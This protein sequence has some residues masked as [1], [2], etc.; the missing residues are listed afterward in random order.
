MLKIKGRNNR[1]IFREVQKPRSILLWIFIL[2][3]TFYMWYI[4]IQQIIL[5]NPVGNKPAPDV[6]L[7]IIWLFF[8]VIVPIITLF[9]LRLIVEVRDDGLYIRYMPF[10]FSYKQFLDK[11]IKYFETINYSPIKRFGGW[12]IR[13]NFNGQR[14]YNMDGNKA[15]ELHFKNQIIVIGTRKP[16]ELN[17]ALKFLKEK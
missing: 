17:K 16:D 7:F 15:L 5:G 6:F 4:F 2:L 12:G 10:H 14:A 1:V 11:D 8:G 13:V 3:F 9:F